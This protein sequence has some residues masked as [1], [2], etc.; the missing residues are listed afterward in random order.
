MGKHPCWRPDRLCAFFQSG[1]VNAAS[2]SN[3][4][5]WFEPSNPKNYQ[6]DE[7]IS[8]RFYHSIEKPNN[9]HN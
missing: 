9:K 1:Y 3:N 2:I 8:L 4:I 7:M 5:A 6:M